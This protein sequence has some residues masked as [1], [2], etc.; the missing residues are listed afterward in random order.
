MTTIRCLLSAAASHKWELHQLD[1]MNAFLHGTL[2]EE[3]YMKAPEGYANPK[4]LVC[5]LKKFTYGMKQASK[6]WFVNLHDELVK[7]GYTQSKND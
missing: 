2:D 4:H 5:K 1:I 3:V 7:Q 6:Q